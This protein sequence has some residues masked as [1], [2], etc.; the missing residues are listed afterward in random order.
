MLT[1]L[2]HY[3]IQGDAPF[4]SLSAL[5]DSEAITVMESLYVD[6]PVADRF[7]EPAQY[8]QNRRQ[9]EHW[10]RDEFIAKGGA[11]REYYPLY[12]VLGYSH[13]MED[14][15]A[16]LELSSVRVPLTIFSPGDI[17]FTYP[18]SMVTYWLGEDKESAHYQSGY[19]GKIF[20]LSDLDQLEHIYGTPEDKGRTALWEGMGPYIEYIEAQIWNHQVL[21]DYLKSVGAAE[22]PE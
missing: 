11:P 16:T 12:A 5:S 1:Y 6:N 7:K 20:T 22:A 14:N 3:Y 10:V 2:T 17:S 18:D 8:M 19:H 15:L 9:V 4:R 21:F 13:W